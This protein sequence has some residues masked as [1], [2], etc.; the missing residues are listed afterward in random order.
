MNTSA[1][2]KADGTIWLSHGDHSRAM[3]DGDQLIELPRDWEAPN[4]KYRDCWV[5]KDGDIIIDLTKAKAQK[6]DEI[7]KE[8]DSKLADTDKEW[9][10]ASSQGKP[11]DAINGKKQALRDIPDEAQKDLAKLRS[12]NTIDAYEPEW[13]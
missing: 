10:I 2:K 8:R 9:M 12:I 7:R 3:E 11:V 13:P 5:E 1:I 4:L 6:L